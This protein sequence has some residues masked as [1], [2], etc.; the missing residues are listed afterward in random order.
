MKRRSVIGLGALAAGLAAFFLHPHKGR[1]RREAV[2]QGG[3]R[4]AR[5]GA[6]AATLMGRPWRRAPATSP[7]LRQRLEDAL[8]EALGGE[9]LALQVAADAGTLTVRGE[10]SSLDQI[11]LASRVIDGFAGEAEVVNLVRL[12]SSAPADAEAG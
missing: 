7:E 12:R 5:R 2:R 4:L 11:S 1:A 9:G 3:E 10:V 8:M 6:G